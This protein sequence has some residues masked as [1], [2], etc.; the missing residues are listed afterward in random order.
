MKLYLNLLSIITNV[1]TIFRQM[2]KRSFALVSLKFLSHSSFTGKEGKLRTDSLVISFSFQHAGTP[3]IME[4]KV[5][6]FQTYATFNRYKKVKK[7]TVLKA[8][9]FERD[10]RVLLR[11]NTGD[12]VV[13]LF[14]VFQ[15]PVCW[16]LDFKQTPLCKTMYFT[17]FVLNSDL[18]KIQLEPDLPKRR[19]G[20]VYTLWSN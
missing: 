18:R 20:S 9:W 10:K 19:S 1:M 17:V 16:S 13:M 3:R 5:T 15:V 12:G 6:Q 4:I 7:Q 11:D 8:Q 2:N 14:M